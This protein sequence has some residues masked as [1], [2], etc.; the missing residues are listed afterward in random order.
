MS[1]FLRIVG[2]IAAYAVF[3]ALVGYFSDSPAYTWF[4]A[5]RAQIKLS[6]SHGANRQADCR[7][8][9]PEEQAK[10]AANMRTAMDCKRERRPLYLELQVDGVVM[11]REWLAPTGLSHDGPSRIYR[12]FQVSP[13][14]HRLL[15][16]LRETARADG[17]DY[18]RD[19][20][21]VIAA[22][23]NLVV[24]FR[25]DLGGFVFK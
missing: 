6:F 5:D 25:A 17:F 15:L 10:L 16:G 7:R 23:Q 8:R 24:D 11:L 14:R 21:V 4:P 3:G 1:A 9:A 2:R 18:R 20:T 22:G 12:I 13:G 19:E